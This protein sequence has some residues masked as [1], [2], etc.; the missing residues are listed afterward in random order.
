MRVERI[1]ARNWMA[2]EEIEISFLDE[3]SGRPFGLVAL[4]GKSGTGKTCV[5][6][7]I[8]S[9]FA[10][11]WDVAGPVPIGSLRDRARPSRLAVDFVFDPVEIVGAVDRLPSGHAL[12]EMAGKTSDAARLRVLLDSSL[13]ATNKFTLLDEGCTGPFVH[14]ACRL[15]LFHVLAK[16]PTSRVLHMPE[17]RTIG[18]S[19]IR[20]VQRIGD[21][22]E[23][24]V[25]TLHAYA[26]F[27]QHLVNLDYL[28]LKRGEDL[29][30]PYR[31][32]VSGLF[33]GKTLRGVTEDLRV[34][35][36]T[37]DGLEVDYD[38][39]SSGERAILALLGSMI[40]PMLEHSVYLIDEPEQ[41]LHPDWQRRLVELFKS[42][43]DRTGSQFILATHAVEVAAAVQELGGAVFSL[44]SRPIEQGTA[45]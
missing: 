25:L 11:R 40:R 7:A 34:A 8:R 26:D 33:D 45:S 9:A 16:G 41:H 5:L 28:S 32:V 23:E 24:R 37:D 19:E 27:K 4:T 6:Q 17:D 39:L 18:R 3:A 44:S 29:L 13:D 14:S 43:S 30:E 22:P 35:F 42:E 12:H 20:Q 15:D 21:R 10:K 31:Q 2:F 36:R 1:H 38:Q